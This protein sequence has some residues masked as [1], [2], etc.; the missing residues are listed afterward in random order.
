M[1]IPIYCTQM[2]ITTNYSMFYWTLLQFLWH[3]NGEAGQLAILTDIVSTC[4]E[5][6]CFVQA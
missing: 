5:D 1:L 2:M 6:M 3:L 4:I